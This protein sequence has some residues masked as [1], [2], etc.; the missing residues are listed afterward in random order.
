MHKEHVLMIQHG[1]FRFLPLKDN[2]I[3]YDFC[4]SDSCFV[5]FEIIIIY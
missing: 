5:D 2:S 4:D 1:E 3:L